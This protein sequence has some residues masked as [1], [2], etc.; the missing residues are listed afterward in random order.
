MKFCLREMDIGRLKKLH[1]SRNFIFYRSFKVN[2][3][4]IDMV[5]PTFERSLD[6][7]IDNDFELSEDEIEQ[8]FALLNKDK[9]LIENIDA[10]V[11]SIDHC[12]DEK[13]ELKK[14]IKN[15]VNANYE[16]VE[17]LYEAIIKDKKV[18]SFIQEILII[19]MID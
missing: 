7:V 4:H 19:R 13:T 6:L 18:I 11:K 17:Q 15:A 12:E 5:I 10:L 9:N 16:S 3:E 2:L 1:K 14:S 8:L